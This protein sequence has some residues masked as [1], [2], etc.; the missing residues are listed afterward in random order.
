VDDSGLY[1][2]VAGSRLSTVRDDTIG[3]TS[4][5]VFAQ[6]DIEWARR[7]RTLLGVRGDLFHFNV[8]SNN[9]LNSGVDNAGLVSPKAT[10][11]FGPWQRTEFY[12]NYGLGYHSNDARGATISVD[13]ITGDPVNRVT[14]LA[15]ARGGEVGVRTVRLHGVQSTVAL[16]YL[17]FDSEL[18]F[19]GDAGVTEAG[20]PSQ[21]KGVEWTNYAR[22][23]SWTTAELDVSFSHA[24][25]T[26]PDPA[27]DHIPGA[28]DRVISGAITVEPSRRVFGS[29][30]LRHFG[31]RPL[32]EDGSVTSQSTTIWNGE[33]GYRVSPR[34]RV[35]IEGFNLL[36]SK[37]ADIDYYYRSRLPGEPL[38][39]IDDIHTHPSLP[40]TARVAMQISF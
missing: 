3:Q 32:V 18:L 40:R 1:H 11:I 22:L 30:R 12:V 4:T 8:R 19:V 31:P 38:E 36:N 25:F 21:R 37:S 35:V 23:T 33:A 34:T 5:G 9:A 14:P 26:D 16:W 17:S 20:R 10:A 2:T 28:L 39:G 29:V 13:P 7:F 6:S 27:G 24:R 15:R